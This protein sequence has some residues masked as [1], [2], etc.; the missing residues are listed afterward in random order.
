V[1][2]SFSKDDLSRK[3]KHLFLA[4]LLL[5]DKPNTNLVKGYV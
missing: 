2:S 1:D 5:F 3:P 4:L